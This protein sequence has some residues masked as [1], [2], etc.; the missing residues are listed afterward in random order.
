MMCRPPGGDD[1][2]WLRA[3]A[4]LDGALTEGGRVPELHHN[5]DSTPRVRVEVVD[6]LPQGRRVARFESEHDTVIAVDNSDGNIPS[7]F[8]CELEGV[9]REAVES[10]L[11]ERNA[12]KPPSGD[13]AHEPPS[14]DE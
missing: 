13:D 5:E 8:L 7:D 14:G 2:P 3:Y 6:H 12:H 4:T 1:E 11:W 10:G 9:L